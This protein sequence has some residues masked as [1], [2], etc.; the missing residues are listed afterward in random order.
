MDIQQ[1]TEAVEK[2]LL[3]LIIRYLRQ[4]Q[5][6]VRTASKLAR[7]F[8]AVLPMKNRQDL[9]QKLKDLSENYDAVKLVY[10]QELSKDEGEREKQA[11]KQMQHAIR[12]GN[13]EHAINVAKSLQNNS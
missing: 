2:E 6:D 5:I 4:S 3:D 9:L 1:Q 13:I 11:L 12:Q 10:Q 7:D 8:L